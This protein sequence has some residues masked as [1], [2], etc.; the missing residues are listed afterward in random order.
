MATKT[1]KTVR[2]PEAEAAVIAYLQELLDAELSSRVRTEVE[3]QLRAYGVQEPQS[4]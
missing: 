2:N 4:A 3:A 1:R